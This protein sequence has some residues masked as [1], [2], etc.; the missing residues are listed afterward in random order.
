VGSRSAE[1]KV[2]DRRSVACPIEHGTHGEYL[3]QRK[4]SVE[5]VA[6][7]QAIDF[8]KVKWGDDLV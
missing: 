3:I 6:A 1:V 5:D 7:A 8:F 4:V 2:V